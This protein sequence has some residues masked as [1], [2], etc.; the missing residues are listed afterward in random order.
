MPTDLDSIDPKAPDFA[1]WFDELPLWSAPFALMLLEAA[2]V[3]PGITV[4]DVGAGTGFLTI[5]LAERCG[6]RSSVIAVDPWRAAMARLR[7][8]IERSGLKNVRLIEEDVVTAPLEAESVDL[9]VSNLGLNNFA[10]RQGALRACHRSARSRAEL[11]LTTNVEGHM[12]EFYSVYRET[13][14]ELGL[15]ECV[16]SLDEHIAHRGTA[17]SVSTLLERAGFG[18][19]DL[20]SDSFHMRF[21]DGSSLLRHHL[22]RA[23]FLPDWKA[24]APKSRT[25][26]VFESLERNLN[27]LASRTGSIALTIPT[28]R[29]RA[30]KP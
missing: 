12:A 11:I 4:L 20:T 23:G 15:S 24:V 8:K 3:R 5:E 7:S 25:R 14:V 6:P 28:L 16:P 9:I 21:A 13:L 1:A 2:P 30:V 10:D 19:A 27:E 22:I 26:A 18:V 17:A 29:L